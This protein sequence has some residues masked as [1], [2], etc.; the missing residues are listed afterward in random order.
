MYYENGPISWNSAKWLVPSFAGG[1]GLGFGKVT[2]NTLK[3]YFLGG[4]EG[5]RWKL[6]K[7]VFYV[8]VEV[9]IFPGEQ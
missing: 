9:W 3:N 7:T 2:G 4:F 6:V 5:L 1:N 8:I